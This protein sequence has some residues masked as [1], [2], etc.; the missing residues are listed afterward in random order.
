MDAGAWRVGTSPVITIPMTAPTLISGSLLAFTLN[1]NAII[2]A[3]FVSGPGAGTLPMAIFPKVRLG[4]SRPVLWPGADDRLHQPVRTRS[5][6][7]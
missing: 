1:V 5:H 6:D 2:I 7:A 3:S 4:V